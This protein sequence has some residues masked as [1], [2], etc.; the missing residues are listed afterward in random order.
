M[1]NVTTLCYIEKEDSYLMLHRVKKEKDLNKDKW[2][3]VGGHLEPGESPE[4]CLLREVREETGLTLLSWKLHGVITFVS[5]QWGTEYMFLYTS[6]EFEGN[7]IS[8]REGNLEW[9]KKSEIS[10]LPIW[11]G[12]KIFFRLLEEE[13]GFFSLKLSYRGDHLTDALT[14]IYGSEK[15]SRKASVPTLPW[16]ELSSRERKKIR[17]KFLERVEHYAAIMGVSYG[18]ICIKNQ[19]TR[20][21]SCSSKGNL[22][23]NYYLYYLDAKLLDYVVVHELAHLKVMNHSF[24]F[25]KEVERHFP[26]YKAC[27]KKLREY[28]PGNENTGK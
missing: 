5:D 28:R 21:G 3:G 18:R 16:G 13:K 25:W 20:W 1:G 7:L 4:E 23:F 26:D 17:E 27:R 8:C 22:N 9:I 14:N 10:R 11:E 24:A 2:V 12:D 6:R 15:G 19:K